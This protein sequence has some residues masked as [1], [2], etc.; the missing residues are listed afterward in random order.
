MT[1]LESLTRARRYTGPKLWHRSRPELSDSSERARDESSMAYLI[2]SAR[3][4]DS[5]VQHALGYLKSLETDPDADDFA[6]VWARHELQRCIHAAT[7]DI[8]RDD[9]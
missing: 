4:Q 5:R 8:L 2:E 3:W 1:W 6:I 7:D 9:S